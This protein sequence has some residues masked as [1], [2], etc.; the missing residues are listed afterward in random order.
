MNCRAFGRGFFFA[1]AQS[2]R[3]EPRPPPIPIIPAKAGTQEKACP[4]QHRAC[5]RRS[6]LDHG[7]HGKD[8]QI[9]RIR[10]P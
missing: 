5:R 8:A 1:W 6:L 9:A 3:A 7:K 4:W 10:F 2:R